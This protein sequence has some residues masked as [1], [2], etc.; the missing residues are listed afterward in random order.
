MGKSIYTKR[1]TA[2]HATGI[3]ALA[4]AAGLGLSGAIWAQNAQQGQ[5]EQARP[6]QQAQQS[7]APK[8]RRVCLRDTGLV[9]APLPELDGSTE[10][11]TGF[12]EH[13][14]LLFF[15]AS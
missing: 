10:S 9:G 12:L 11:S 8:S 14:L 4:T 1:M 2:A 15:G 3:S 5:G 13:H 6:S 7:A